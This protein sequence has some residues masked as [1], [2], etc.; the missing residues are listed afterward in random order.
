ML[1]CIRSQLLQLLRARE[2]W[3]VWEVWLLKH[4]PTHPPT[5]LNFL[6]VAGSMLARSSA[7]THFLYSS[8]LCF[9]PANMSGSVKPVGKEK[10]MGENL[11][12]K[13]K[14]KGYE[15]GH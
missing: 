2:A 12:G 9:R 8:R 10:V 5:C 11:G 1:R 3:K 6:C 4:P 7:E 14:R 13:G 15:L